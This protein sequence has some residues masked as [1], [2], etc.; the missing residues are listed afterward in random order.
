MAFRRWAALFTLSA[1]LE[2]RVWSPSRSSSRKT[3]PNLYVSLTGISGSGKTEAIN[4]AK[5]IL[6]TIDN[7]HMSPDD[8]TP[9]GFYDS[10]E[11]SLRLHDQEMFHALAVI[12]R[13]LGDLL[14]HYDM[15]FLSKLSDLFDNPPDHKARRRTSK[16][17]SGNLYVKIEYPTVNILAGVT[18]AYLGDLM[19]EAAWGQGFCSRMIFIH[20]PLETQTNI[21][22][23]AAQAKADL[24]PLK[25][26]IQQV[27]NLWGEFE[28]SAEAHDALNQ[29]NA[30]GLLPRPQHSRLR[31]YCTRRLI[32]VIKLSMLSSV[33][34]SNR[35][36][37]TL[38]D[39]ERGLEWLLTAEDQMPD[40]FRA[41]GQKPEGAILRDLH[42]YLYT[43]H[44][45]I[46]RGKRVP[47]GNDV[48]WEFL[49]ERIESYRIPA[50]IES[51]KR[52]GLLEEV[53]PG[54]WLATPKGVK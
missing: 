26:R 52:I 41:M 13:E 17:G 23:L 12:S 8:I 16:S 19:P 31:E 35:L 20:A 4:I 46:E 10:L 38:P 33:S 48:I 49:Q 22:V 34:R 11:E 24:N 15:G 6:S 37:V 51:G 14:P 9:A 44:A 54:R 47:V 40:I 43:K 21:D 53:A 27:F 42:Y 1:A 18:P 25:D 3:F 36:V 2:R 30:D 28:W 45:K 29:W 5:E 7:I 32:H 39:F 50:L